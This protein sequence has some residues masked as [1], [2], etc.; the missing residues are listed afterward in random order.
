[1]TDVFPAVGFGAGYQSTFP[2]TLDKYL[3]GKREQ[4]EKEKK[5]LK[6]D[7]LLESEDFND[8]TPL[9]KKIIKGEAEGLIPADAARLLLA[10]KKT[11][12]LD[13]SK[14]KS[15]LFRDLPKAFE[16]VYG[17]T[18]W[19]RLTPE[20]KQRYLDIAENAYNEF[21]DPF[22]AEQFTLDAFRNAQGDSEAAF[23]KADKKKERQ[24]PKEEGSEA[25]SFLGGG[26]GALVNQFLDRK[27]SKFEKGLE[28]GI[29]EGPIGS[30]LGQQPS[31]EE[32]IAR[33]QE[34]P[35]LA[36][37]TGEI[38][39][40]ILGDLPTLA[41]GSSVGGAPAALLFTGL[42]KRGGDEVWNGLRD[43]DKY[44]IEKGGEAAYRV[45]HGAAKDLLL[46][47]LFDRI[48]GLKKAISKLPFAKKFLEN[49]AADAILSSAAATGVIGT[50][51]PILEA[52]LPQANDYLNA[53]KTVVG[54]ELLNL[55]VNLSNK[56]ASAG[57]QSGR[58]PQEFSER[59]AQEYA[60]EGGNREA[61]N[62]GDEREVAKLD[63]AIEKV[64]QE[65]GKAEK[66]AGDILREKD[67]SATEA[68]RP[69]LE[70]EI[71]QEKEIARK[72]SQ[73]P[74][75]KIVEPPKPTKKEQA[76]ID[77]RENLQ[78]Q[79]KKAQDQL[80][81]LQQ[82]R[83]EAPPK[84]KEGK[85]NLEIAER[86]AK[87]VIEKGEEKI[88]ELNKRLKDLKPK[89]QEAPTEK[90]TQKSIVRHLD[91]LVEASKNPGGKTD[92]Y[93][94]K[95][96]ERDEKHIDEALELLKSGELPP[97]EY[98]H[99]ST[100]ILEKYHDAYSNLL[101]DTEAAIEKLKGAKDK[102]S[103]ATRKELKKLEA[104]LKKNSRI[105]ESKR[106]VRNQKRLIREKFKGP[107]KTFFKKYLQ[108]LKANSKMLEKDFFKAK[109]ALSQPDVKI[110]ELGMEKLRSLT[111]KVAR[112]PTEKNAKEFAEKTGIAEEE[113]RAAETRAKNEAKKFINEIK[114]GKPKGKFR[115]FVE[116]ELKRYKEKG[117]KTI[118]KAALGGLLGNSIQYLVEEATGYK[119]PITALSFILPGF[120][121]VRFGAAIFGT[122]F[123]KLL[124]GGREFYWHTQY[125]KAKTPRERIDISTKLRDK[126]WTP[127][128]L[129]KVYKA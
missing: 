108:D 118:S 66:T 9:Q 83:T 85:A 69:A 18:S 75:E 26:L 102:D 52:R 8:L 38:L 40:G 110:R 96:F 128:Q 54:F 107:G 101:K 99:F 97:P 47:Y 28:R 15:T 125:H 27:P 3:K 46:G 123:N 2:D 14:A 86:S 115:E 13:H 17:K 55:P 74:F 113:V 37:Q 117:L 109:E 16:R 34:D 63:D 30:L 7:K 21:L 53:L 114:E 6:L 87:G 84:S 36:Q 32:L 31:D 25:L 65:A 4:R 64:Q 105:N 73:K 45:A 68:E 51:E 48:P 12:A 95:S 119:P 43:K 35:G 92:E 129:E 70:R 98:V 67:L 126:G 90:E 72:V 89:P 82:I 11:S 39:G 81:E 49:K 61:L 127:K 93:Y 19:E 100:E 79:L 60:K 112:D 106:L 57:A 56:I 121:K 71:E 50:A 120:N 59:V 122:I 29:K 10:P 94:Q 62:L 88:K 42:L 78:K 103:V 104:D 116:K 22:K 124:E 5:S 23:A 76:I 20:E 58:S 24:N 44:T 80:V 91:E 33:G 77:E 41:V 1:M 111:E